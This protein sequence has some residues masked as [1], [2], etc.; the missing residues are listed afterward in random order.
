MSRAKKIKTEEPKQE[1]EETK[2]EKK[3]PE[4]EAIQEQIDKIN[5]EEDEKIMEIQKEYRKKKTT[6]FQ[7]K[8]QNLCK[9]SKLL[10]D[11]ICEAS[12]HFRPVI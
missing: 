7:A 4:L 5:V 12:R 3:N 11:Y 9:D 2:E 8:E 1:Q 6:T 10:V